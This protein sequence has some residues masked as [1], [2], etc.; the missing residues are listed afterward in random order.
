MEARVLDGDRELG[1]EGEQQRLLV[2]GQL[3][4]RIGIDREHAD[5]L[6]ASTERDGDRGL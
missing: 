1:R 3:T 2:L 5:Q 6:V 4:A